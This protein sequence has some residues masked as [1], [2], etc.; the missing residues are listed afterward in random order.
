MSRASRFFTWVQ[1]PAVR[2][3]GVGFLAVAVGFLM[4]LDQWIVLWH[5]PEIWG[6]P[7]VMI[8][9]AHRHILFPEARDI[10]DGH[11]FV[12]DT[13][14]YE[15]RNGPPVTPWPWLPPLLYA[16]IWK[17][18]GIALFLPV[19]TF[20][21][22][23]V[24]FVLLVVIIRDIT[25]SWFLALFAA[26]LTFFARLAPL[27]FFPG[28]AD[29]LKVL[30]NLFLPDVFPVTVSRV[31][32]LPYESFNPTFLV[33]GPFFFLLHRSL[34][35]HRPRLLL[36]VGLLGGLLIYCYPFHWIFSGTL[37]G[38]LLC[39]ALVTKR[40]KWA[41][42][43]TLAI[44]INLLTTLPFW[45]NQY[46]LDRAGILSEINLRNAGFE[47]G[48]LIRFSQW[49]WYV[50]WSALTI[51]IWFVAQRRQEKG[52]AVFLGGLF[53][54][55]IVCLNLQ[56]VTN[57]NIHPDHWIT[58]VSFL[59][60]GWALCY[61][62]RDVLSFLPRSVWVRTMVGVVGVLLLV[63]SGW[64]A[65]QTSLASAE[66]L[67]DRP[68]F[69]RDVAQAYAWLD[70]HATPDAVVLAPSVDVSAYLT[71]FTHT[72]SFL[73]H[74]LSTFA[75]ES[76]TL[77]RLYAVYALIGVPKEYLAAQ[78]RAD[79][80][81]HNKNYPNISGPDFDINKQVFLVKFRP[82]TFDGSLAGYEGGGIP[83]TMQE[84]IL[85]AYADYQFDMATLKKKYRLDYVLST[86]QDQSVGTI[87]LSSRPELREVFRSGDVILY[88]LNP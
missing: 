45:L 11:F 55:L 6:R 54:A 84:D 19:S 83:N 52:T 13:Q 21:V 12:A 5:S 63:G 58:K 56:I 37:F 1:Q 17:I 74:S 7:L 36:W 42:F 72:R 71:I 50:L 87:P 3:L 65:L 48:R 23:I 22:A 77:D 66:R 67:V 32:F 4:S 18:F 70:T 81:W 47:V 26:L 46:A 64:G 14:L 31:D 34:A 49:K 27:M 39:G 29:E 35:R 86:P 9:D 88:D 28:N 80:D 59:P 44:G 40:W 33:L 75:S 57:V 38:V 51:W 16:G 8:A 30:I 76:E 43:I 69:S 62:L 25:R 82:Q 41:R 79:W 10:L 53:V 73:P 15:Y 68:L 61:L 24:S 78:L 2:W 85:S 20:L 60:L